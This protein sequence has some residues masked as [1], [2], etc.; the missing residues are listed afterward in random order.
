MVSGYE[1]TPSVWPIL[2]SAAFLLLL[3]VL[4][5]RHREVQGAVP[6]AILALLVALLCLGI[7]AES[8]A[9]G[10]DARRLWFLARDALVL[11]SGILILWSPSTPRWSGT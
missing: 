3:G 10:E 4:L 11:P 6:L 7:A 8:A 5:W 1:F 9:T 2:A